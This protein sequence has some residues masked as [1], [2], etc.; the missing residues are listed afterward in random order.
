MKPGQA[1]LKAAKAARTLNEAVCSLNTADCEWVESLVARN[2][3]YQELSREFLRTVSLIDELFS[4]AIGKSM[5]S[6]PGT[7]VL[8]HKKGR[9]KGAVGNPV[10]ENFLRHILLFTEEAGGKLTFD[11]NSKKGTLITAL[12]V[13]RPHLRGVVPNALAYRTIQRIITK[14]LKDQR[15]EPKFSKARRLLFA[16]LSLNLLGLP[17]K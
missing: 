17:A 4:T 16:D 2:P 9:V 10:F 14:F 3:V 12:N 11:K 8:R 7:A 13:L 5:L 1:L 15:I 6:I